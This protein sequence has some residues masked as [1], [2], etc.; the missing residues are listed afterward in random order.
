MIF[1]KIL[2]LSQ[3]DRNLRTKVITYLQLVQ[4]VTRPA[5]R[6]QA[7]T[8]LGKCL[9]V[10]NKLLALRCFEL[11]LAWGAPWSEIEPFVQKLA[12]KTV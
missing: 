8:H 12:H 11:A 4:S 9:I 3:N 2:T 7:F 1:N 5:E 10:E 6:A